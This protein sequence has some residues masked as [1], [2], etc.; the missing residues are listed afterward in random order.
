MRIDYG[1]TVYQEN[2]STTSIE[3]DVHFHSYTEWVPYSPTKHIQHCECGLNGTVTANHVVKSSDKTKCMICGAT[4][5]AIGGLGESFIQNIQKVT[6]NGSYI[7]PNGII[8]LVDEDIEA[9][10]NGTLVFYDKDNLPQVQ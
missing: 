1:D 2:T 10:L 3:Y 8:V 7:L 4:I 9:Y 5:E 6:I